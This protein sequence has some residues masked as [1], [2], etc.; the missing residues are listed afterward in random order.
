MSRLRPGTFGSVGEPQPSVEPDEQGGSERWS[1]PGLPPEGLSSVIAVLAMAV[2][3]G[4]AVDQAAWVGQ[5]PG[6]RANQTAF[7]P[8]AMLVAAIVGGLLGRS[9]MP[10]LRAHLIGASVGAL[11][12]LNAVAGAISRAPTLD[13][14]LRALNESVSIYAWESVG[15]GIRSSETSVFLL[16]T[17]ALLWSAA[18]LGAFHV[19]RRR[20]PMPLIALGATALLINVSLTTQDQYIHLVV[21]VAAALLLVIRLNLLNEIDGWRARRLID[22]PQAGELFLSRGAAFVA[23]ALVASITLAATASSA[24]LARAWRDMDSGLLEFGY[25]VNRWLGG[26]SGAIRGSTNLFGPTQTLRDVWESSTE[27]VFTARVGDDGSYYWRG[28]TY[29]S[30]DGRTW[31]QL[32]PLAT[33]VGAGQNTFA[34]SAEEL[35]ALSSRRQ[36]AVSVSSISLGGDVIVIPESPLVVDRTVE[37]K[38]HRGEGGFIDLRLV[39]GVRE[40]TQYSAI[41]YVP[42]TSGADAITA[43]KL[44]AAGT[45]YP[46]WVS[47]YL[48]I[49]PESIGP[50]TYEEAGAIFDALPADKRNPYHVAEA[51]QNWFWA[52]GGFEYTTNVSG[53]CAG[54]NLVDCFLEDRRGFCERFATAMTMMLRTQGIPARYV[55]GYLPGQSLGEGAWQ[56]DRSASHAWVEVYFP[57]YGWY[58]F[59]PTPGNTVNGQAPTELREG[60]PVPAPRGSFLPPLP[61]DRFPDETFEAPPSIGPIAP[62]ATGGAGSDGVTQALPLVVLLLAAVTLV[63]LYATRVRRRSSPLEAGRAYDAMARLA[64]RLGHGP[65]PTQTIY[66]YTGSLSQLVPAVAAD[67]RTLATA[68]VEATYARRPQT[69]ALGHRLAL[70]YRRV[71]LNLLRLLFRRPRWMRAPTEARRRHS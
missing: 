70:A 61:P 3:V 64:T 56:I 51:I 10:V 14:R 46:A 60:N 30:F 41:A 1:L 35:A 68:K 31:Q 40:G 25:A 17:G 9:R 69:W 67:L 53:I 12:L 66:E 36:L 50:R 29:D 45:D 11:F 55:V 33:I 54:E 58:R 18:Q 21:F 49:R 24:P 47:R 59:D 6:S 13:E 43:N 26:V 71:R 37:L 48:E 57:G 63:M 38:T 8:L 2:V 65:R 62:G 22:V 32:D 19:F 39:D 4:F 7:L 44:A 16:L 5:I 15:M 27:P 23:L 34:G 28:A 42:Q 20:R 52:D